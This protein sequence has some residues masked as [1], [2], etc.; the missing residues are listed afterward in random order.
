MATTRECMLGIEAQG[1]W[2]NA[3]T[4]PLEVVA[5]KT[6]N[7]ALAGK[8]LYIPGRMNQILNLIGKI[9]PRSWIAAIIYWRW[10]QTQSKWLNP[11]N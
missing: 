10:N 6:L 8:S 7:R 5:Y 4:N 11:K 9:I 2:G 1:F 3:T